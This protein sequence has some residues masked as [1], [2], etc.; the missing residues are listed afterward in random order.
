MESH[1][2]QCR[3]HKESWPCPKCMLIH[4]HECVYENK[5]G[6]NPPHDVTQLKKQLE[7]MGFD[8]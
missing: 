2:F 8:T 4:Y 1:G 6:K 5:N 7:K 3:L